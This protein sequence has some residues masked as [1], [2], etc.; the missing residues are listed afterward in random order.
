MFC[1]FAFP[2]RVPSS[3]R[4]ALSES[5]CEKPTLDIASSCAEIFR[6]SKHPS[7]LRLQDKEMCLGIVG[8]G[9]NFRLAPRHFSCTSRIYYTTFYLVIL[10]CSGEFRLLI[11]TATFIFFLS[12]NNGN[13]HTIVGLFQEIF[14]ERRLRGL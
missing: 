9:L 13:L 5:L 14:F 7:L 4:Q 2:K 11:C 8:E 10:A 6:N 3:T 1:T 12:F